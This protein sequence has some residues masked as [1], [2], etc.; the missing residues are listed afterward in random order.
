MEIVQEFSS[1]YMLY[2]PVALVIV[3]AILVFTFGFK[4]AEQPPFDKLSSEDR[5]SAGKKKKIK[6]KVR[7]QP[8]LLFIYA[9]LK[10]DVRL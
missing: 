9:N 7:N 6:E 1:Q 4:S 3:G 2:I 8:S 10:L 5:K